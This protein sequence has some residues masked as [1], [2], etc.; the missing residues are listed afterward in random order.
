MEAACSMKAGVSIDMPLMAIRERPKLTNAGKARGGDRPRDLTNSHA[1]SYC[2]PNSRAGHTGQAADY[3]NPRPE[4]EV[5]S[6]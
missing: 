6:G 1:E 3:L 4:R 5:P 2:K